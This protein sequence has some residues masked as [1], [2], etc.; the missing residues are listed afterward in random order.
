MPNLWIYPNAIS[1]IAAKAAGGVPPPVALSLLLG[2]ACCAVGL[3]A[4]DLGLGLWLVIRRRQ[5]YKAPGAKQC[6]GARGHRS[7]GFDQT[8]EALRDGFDSVLDTVD[9]A[10]H[11]RDRE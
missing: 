1:A 8:S 9:P 7:S 6:C 3:L 10:G 4:G 5:T 11:R 2:G